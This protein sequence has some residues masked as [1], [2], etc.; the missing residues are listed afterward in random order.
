HEAGTSDDRTPRGVHEGISCLA[1]HENHSNASRSS[2]QNCH[3]AI[4]NC[5]RD[6]TTMNTTF[7]DRKS[8]HNIHFVRCID[9]HTKGIPP[10]SRSQ[11]AKK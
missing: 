7:F 9:C 10:K 6:V 2:C 1:C 11:S 3:P 8:P 5:Q 4:S